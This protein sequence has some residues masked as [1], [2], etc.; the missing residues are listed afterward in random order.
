M[1]TALAGTPPREACFDFT[2]P[3]RP[4]GRLDTLLAEHSDKLVQW[5]KDRGQVRKRELQSAIAEL[6]RERSEIDEL[7]LRVNDT[8]LLTHGLS[9]LHSRG[10]QVKGSVQKALESTRQRSQAALEAR[11]RLKEVEVEKL[12]EL[13][14]Q[15]EVLDKQTKDSAKRLEEVDKFLNLYR[16]R[17]GLSLERVAPQTVRFAF[18]LLDPEKLEKEYSLTLRWTDEEE[19]CIIASHPVLPSQWHNSLLARLNARAPDESSALASFIVGV[20]EAFKRL[21]VE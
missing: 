18:S 8:G 12:E 19:Y 17:L 21:L 1:A 20:R 2:A 14:Q 10:C 16:D 15:R 7:S 13:R 9:K 6:G 11:Q 5:R 4:A 3:P